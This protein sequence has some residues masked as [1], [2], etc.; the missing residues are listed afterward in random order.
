[1]NYSITRNIEFDAGHRVYKHES[2]CA[3]V[4]GH[5]YRVEITCRPNNGLDDLGRVVDF[6]VVKRIVG[7]WVDEH[8]D[9]GML[10][11]CEDPLVGVWHKHL[12]EH[13]IFTMTDNPTAENIAEFLYHLSNNLLLDHNVKVTEVT[14]YETPN[15]WAKYNESNDS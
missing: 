6:S 13:K 3:H 1:M 14:V 2:K 7:G 15:C 10:F 8:F 9:H 4:H 11:F 12:P 5:R